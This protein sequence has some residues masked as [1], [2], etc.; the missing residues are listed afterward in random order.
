MIGVVVM[1]LLGF[2]FIIVLGSTRSHLMDRIEKWA[3]F[4]KPF[5]HRLLTI[6][7]SLLDG[8]TSIRATKHVGQIVI[9]TIFSAVRASG[10]S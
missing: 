8:L 1:T 5:A 3:I 10:H 4:E 2:G 6:M 7:N 9:H